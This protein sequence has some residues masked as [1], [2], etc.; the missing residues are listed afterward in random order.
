MKKIKIGITGMTCEHCVTSVNKAINKVKG[1]IEVDTSLSKGESTI[2]ALDDIKVE[3][4]KKNIENAGYTPSA[5][6]TADVSETEVRK[7]AKV[8]GGQTG[9]GHN[10]DYDLIVIGGGSAAF[11]SAIKFAD[12]GKK[13]CVIENWV[14]GGTCLNRGCVPS[15]HLLEAARIYYEPLS[16]KFK[17]IETKQEHIDIKE[18]IKRKTELLNSLRAMKYYNVLKGYNNITF[19]EAEGRFTSKNSVEVIPNDKGIDSY[20][21]TSD[22]FII[23]TGGANQIIGINGL[24]EVGYITNEEILN[25]DYLPETLLILGTRAV[26]LEF[27]QMFRRFGSKVVAIGRSG[28]ILLNEEPEISEA[29]LQILKNEGIEF[30][31]NSSIKRLYKKDGKK[32]AEIE[33][34]EGLKTV[35]FDELL[36]ATGITGN[37]EGLNLEAVGVE[38]YKQ[39]YIKVDGELK[40][41]NPDIYACG[42]VTGIMRLVTT[43]AYDG[44]IAAYNLLNEKHIKADYS[45]VAHTTFTDPE[46]SS[47][48]LAEEAAIK[49]GYDVIKVVFPIEYVPKAQSI[50]KIEGLI[51]MIADKKTNKV[52]GIHMLAHNSSETIQQASVY[53]QN[54]YTIQQIGE[55]I[56]VYP[57][58]AEGLKLAAQSFTK[59][60][61]KLSCCA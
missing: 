8:E 4:I 32:Y 37:T 20:K 50:F 28:R 61:S 35:K 29:L 54:S 24:G 7:T 38:T 55:E 9:S 40:T 43:A 46:V 52:L 26:S 30:L 47:V 13:V 1:V 18:L 51:K 58:M 22:K 3:D 6:E 31:L 2:L 27:A 23:A 25:L 17:G 15:K 21:I 14:I 44:K 5:H 16:N 19:I 57:T 60:V 48:G 33:T 39:G 56:G 42:D 53:L 11:S 10:Y 59:D 45:S 12:E 36:M 34:E 49:E 41:T